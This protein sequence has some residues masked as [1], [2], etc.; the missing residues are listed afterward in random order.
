MK[1][2]AMARSS[3]ARTKPW[4]R[5]DDDKVT[6]EVHAFVIK[7][8]GGC[9]ARHYDSTMVCWGKVTLDHVKSEARMGVRAESDPDHLVSICQ[10]HSEDGRKAGYQWNTA[11]RDKEREYL[12]SKHDQS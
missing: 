7:R 12:E 4:K 2:T 10:G 8:D 11:N 6:P 5:S 9:I 3:S 1:R